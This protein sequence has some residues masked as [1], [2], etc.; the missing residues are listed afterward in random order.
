MASISTIKPYM[1]LFALIQAVV[2]L[3][4]EK[5]AVMFEA[6]FQGECADGNPCHHNCYDLHDGTFECSC[7]E[8]YTLANNGYSCIENIRNYSK[9]VEAPEEQQADDMTVISA[10]HAQGVRSYIPESLSQ[11]HEGYDTNQNDGRRKIEIDFASNLVDGIEV[12]EKYRG[13]QKPQVDYENSKSAS[14]ALEVDRL[15]QPMNT[16][17]ITTPPSPRFVTCKELECESGGACIPD[18]STEGVKCSCPLGRGGIYCETAVDLKYPQFIGSS[19]LA[20]PVLRDAHKSMQISLEFRPESLDGILLYSGEHADLQGDFA[21]L[22]LNKGFVEFRFDCGMGMGVL[23]SVRPVVPRSWNFINV[24]R[25]RWDAWLQLNNGKQVQGRSKGLFSR[26]TFRQNLYLGGSP[27]VSLIEERTECQQGF[28]GCVRRLEINTRKYDFRSGSRGDAVEGADVGEC[29]SDVCNKV[30]CQHG[31][32]CVAASPDHGICL[33]PLGYIGDRC[34]Q[35][36]EL[37]VPFFNGSSYLEYSGLGSSAL[38]FIELLVVFKPKRPDGVLFYNG[39]KIDGTGDFMAI[40]LVDGFVEFRFDL[41]TGPAIVR[42]P[43]PVEM[44]EWH[45]LFVSRT[46]RDGSLE[47]DTQPR[48]EGMSQGAFTQ[49]S[50]PLNLYIGGVSDL[51]DVAEKAR[52]TASFS[53]CIQKV[54]INNKP[55]KLVEDALS[56]ANIINCDHQCVDKPCQNGGSCVPK[57]DFYTCHCLLGFAGSNCQQEVTEMIAEPMFSGN[58]YLYYLDENIMRR[59]RGNSFNIQ[60]R[61]RAYSPDA[62]VMWA[63]DEEMSSSS[64]FLALGIKDGYLQL[65]YN[66]GSGEVLISHNNSRID[67]GKWHSVRAL[68]NEQEGSLVIDDS[69]TEMGASAG[70]LKQLNVNNGLYLGGMKDIVHNTLNKYQRGFVGCL[71]NVT[72]STDFHIRLVTHAA[73]GVN[74]Q[75]CV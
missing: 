19:Y 57:V 10:S 54:I 72:L 74:V 14:Q 67:D 3:G 12:G 29:S 32:Q 17:T 13:I 18:P 4:A 50:L 75:P 22:T 70:S 47:V 46:G 48:V 21:A 55:L 64:D 68:R 51:Q 31:G 16:V 33:C 71:S 69:P 40:S 39:Y 30:T 43:E 45:T 60:F 26:I 28:I 63:G 58:S 56:G 61:L 73:L 6:A 7:N 2:G 23:R 44:D 65:R 42:S 36:V 66:L 11:T 53:G 27:N 8:G 38:S 35:A 37:V 1:F 52:I 59:V 41:G 49:L 62:L 24:Y 9:T 34:E 20:L 15:F 5:T 25:D